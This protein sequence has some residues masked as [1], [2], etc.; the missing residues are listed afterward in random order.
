MSKPG[1]RP[2]TERQPSSQQEEL[3][4]RIEYEDDIHTLQRLVFI[5]RLYEGDSVR[6]AAKKVHLSKSTGHDLLEQWND[7]RTEDIIADEEDAND[8]TQEFSD[9]QQRCIVRILREDDHL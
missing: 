1:Q 2:Q 3:R 7:S 9:R 5:T 4:Q 6:D 8:Q